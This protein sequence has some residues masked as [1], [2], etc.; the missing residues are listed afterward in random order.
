MKINTHLHLQ[1]VVCRH[2][3]AFHSIYA[4]FTCNQTGE[5]FIDYL[6]A[7]VIQLVDYKA[8]NKIAISC[9]N[10]HTLQSEV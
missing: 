5:T 2:E 8:Y 1:T 10:E 7:L 9:E 6:A 4:L 3:S